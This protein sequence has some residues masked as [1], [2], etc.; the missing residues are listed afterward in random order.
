MGGILFVEAEYYCW[1]LLGCALLLEY[2]GS[3]EALLRN[4]NGGEIGDTTKYEFQPKTTSNAG[5]MS[6]KLE[7]M[8]HIAITESNLLRV[9]SGC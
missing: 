1:P 5:F 7:L 9:A 4:K 3:S 2:S 6:I 8:A